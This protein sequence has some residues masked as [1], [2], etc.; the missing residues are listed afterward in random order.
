MALT[1]TF[2]LI[3]TVLSPLQGLRR[4]EYVRCVLF[5]KLLSTNPISPFQPWHILLLPWDIPEDRDQIFGC[6]RPS[7]I[8]FEPGD[9]V[10]A[11]A[12][13]GILTEDLRR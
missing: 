7:E 12:M 11:V 5:T 3:L 10:K 13:H 2:D 4:S 8:A 1:G 9:S 6:M